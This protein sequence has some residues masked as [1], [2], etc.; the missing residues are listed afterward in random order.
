MLA[1]FV[2]TEPISNEDA[3]CYPI[4]RKPIP[5]RY[6]ATPSYP[7]LPFAPS[8][9]TRGLCGCFINTHSKFLFHIPLVHACR[10]M[11]ASRASLAQ[12]SDHSF[13]ESKLEAAEVSKR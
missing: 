10:D 2:Y 1:V 11:A 9:L 12:A 13:W 3:C 8:L 5:H 7:E 6:C 4:L